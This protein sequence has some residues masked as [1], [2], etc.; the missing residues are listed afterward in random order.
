MSD[1]Y[2]LIT[3]IIAV[4]NDRSVLERCIKS[5]VSQTYSH[6]ELIIMDGGSTDGSVDL[7]NSYIKYI[8]YW[9]SKPDRGIYHAWN[10]ALTHAHGEW[11]CFMGADDFFWNEDVLAELSPHLEDAHFNKIKIAYGRVTKVDA[12]ENIKKILG[13]PWQKIK[14]L[15]PHGMPLHLPHPGMMHHR[16]LFERHGLFDE[17]FMIAGDYEF[18]L[19]ELKNGKALFVEGVRTVGSQIGG[20]ADFS[21]LQTNMETVRAKQK[22]GL[23]QFSWVWIAVYIRAL[24]RK[25]WRNYLCNYLKIKI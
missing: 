21:D 8:A 13:K 24:V 17:T 25:P 2:P 3:I 9:E 20:I 11:I 22:N 12:Q 18:L 14:W 6:K 10:K 4:L 19:R 16:S 1:N 23:K 7:I 5:I 15:M